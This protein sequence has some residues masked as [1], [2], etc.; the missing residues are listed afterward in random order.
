M[1]PRRKGSKSAKSEQTREQIYQRAMELFRAQGYDQTT[2]RQIAEKA[3]VATGAAY[4][5]FR[6]K[7]E[8][9]LR[10]YRELHAGDQA[11][12][13]SAPFRKIHDLEE[14]LHRL[15]TYKLDQ[16]QAHRHFLA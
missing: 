2:M 14:R 4:Y 8:I 12:V 13:D 15:I 11:F 16:L 7:E 6:S 3:E 5:Y 10:F 1:S 9:V